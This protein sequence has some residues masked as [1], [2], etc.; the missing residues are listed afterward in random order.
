M[1]ANRRSAA[2]TRRR[3]PDGPTLNVSDV[4]E[5]MSG[6]QPSANS[7][8]RQRFNQRCISLW[9][10]AQ[11]QN[12]QESQ[13]RV[14][15][16][17]GDAKEQFSQ[18]E[19]MFPNLDPELVWNTF[20]ET[21]NTQ[22]ALDTLLALSAAMSS[23]SG[24]AGRTD[25]VTEACASAHVANHKHEAS[26]VD[27]STWPVLVDSDGW[28]IVNFQMLRQ[29]EQ[30]LGSVWCNTAKDAASLPTP[31]VAPNTLLKARRKQMEPQVSMRTMDCIEEDTASVLTDYELR[32]MRG[33]LRVNKLANKAAARGMTQTYND[34]IEYKE[35][36]GSESADSCSSLSETAS[37]S[38]GYIRQECIEC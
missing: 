4:P 11:E 12:W 21:P 1:L 14:A 38:E 31:K 19:K 33:Q 18:L 25:A 28:E 13:V 9:K 17:K 15:C 2:C 35:R 3:A 6:A 34:P 24:A 32:Q 16:E 22:D 20:Q 37:E 23:D 36:V 5:I 30:D 10:D 8:A 7:V 29:Q 26:P 27:S